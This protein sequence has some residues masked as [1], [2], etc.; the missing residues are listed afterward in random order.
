MSNDTPNEIVARVGN[1]ASVEA[2]PKMEGRTM[3]LLL[4]PPR[5][6]GGSAPRPRPRAPGEAPAGG[7]GPGTAPR[8]EGGPTVE[9]R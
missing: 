3:T 4:A 1:Q 7:P 2:E 6:G 8:R 5:A 9:R